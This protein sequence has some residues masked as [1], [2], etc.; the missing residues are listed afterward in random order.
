MLDFEKLMAI[1]NEASQAQVV[2]Y[3]FFFTLAT[4]IHARQVRYEIRTQFTL[5][6]ASIDNL[7]R[8][9][10]THATRLDKVEEDVKIIKN[11]L[12]S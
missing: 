12:G 6:T 7:S 11:K 8:S 10:D 1:L 4:L 9:L 3:G 2:H 5:L